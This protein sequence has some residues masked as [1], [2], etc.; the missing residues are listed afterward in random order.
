[1][2]SFFK[3]L[4][5][6]LSS[7]RRRQF[8]ALLLL[9]L[10][11]STSEIVSFGAV[12]PFLMA[13][14]EP[15]RVLGLPFISSMIER[16]ALNEPRQPILL[17]S[18]IFFIAIAFAGLLRILLLWATTRLSFAAGADLSIDMY[19]RTLH[20]PYSV[21]CSRNSSEIINSITVKANGVIYSIILPALTLLSA[22]IT[23]TCVLIALLT[24]QPFIALAALSSISFIYLVIVRITRQQLLRDS[25][26]IA[27]ESTQLI[28][29][30][31]E[32]LGGIR[33]VLIDGSQEV[34]VNSYRNAD[35][36]LRRSQGNSFF[37]SI[38]PRYAVETLGMLFI[39][40]LAY[41]FAQQPHGIA[42]VIPVLGALAL[43]AQRLLPLLQNAYASW[44]QISSGLSSLED[45]L[46]LLEQPLPNNPI[47]PSA[48][49]SFNRDISLHQLGFR[50]NNE[51]PFILKEI[52]LSIK[53]GSRVGIIGRT[54]SGKSTLLDIIMGLLP[55]TEGLLEVDGQPITQDNLRK[56]QDHIAHVP[57]DIFLADTTVEE[58]IA[59]G[60]P[61][62]QIDRS[63]VKI[64]AD[65]AQIASTIESL[66][67]GYQTLVGERGV[68]LSGG[69]RQR[70]GIA[71]ALY[72][73]ADVIVFDEATSALDND[74][75]QAV[76]QAIDT[77]ST[78][79]TIIIIAHRL[80]TLRNCSQ[81]IEIADGTIKV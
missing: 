68:R 47:Y 80:T 8:L 20:Q 37:I 65:Q 21:H 49:L 53:K 41:A 28:K 19:N 62:D 32:G 9:M 46:A 78:D 34:Y 45:T 27:R 42:L 50:Y 75:E 2:I 15:E 74:T 4:W 17:F 22:S 52:N 10:L 16:L 77:L 26:C 51:S 59:F 13:L 79:L 70:I 40:A 72:K 30:L 76:M 3:R 48:P 67:K 14:T 61:N 57:Q 12:F 73:R 66:A 5:L 18:V 25:V 81:I 35:T 23:V 69:Q 24:I 6:H 55:A 63:R 58:N 71:R 54:G 29:S 39:V 44:A 31:T 43:G 1:M 7:R 38:S 33:D 60:I 36:R 64:A 56:W 11:V